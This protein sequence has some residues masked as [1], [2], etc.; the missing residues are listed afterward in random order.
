MSSLSSRQAR[1]WTG[2][3]GSWISAAHLSNL[4]V[5]YC[6]VAMPG[7]HAVEVRRVISHPMAH[8]HYS[9]TLAQLGVDRE[10][11][12]DTVDTVEM[13]RLRS[14][15]MLD[16]T[17]IT[18]PRASDLDV[19][20]HGLQ[21]ESWN[22]THFRLLSKPPSPVTLPM[23]ADT[24]GRAPLG[25]SSTDGAEERKIE[26]VS[27]KGVC[28]LMTQS[29]DFTELKVIEGTR[30]SDPA[31]TIRWQDGPIHDPAHADQAWL[32]ADRIFFP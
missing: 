15:R 26:I 19:L 9:R 7:V 14:N 12:E 18:S 28:D 23:D 25:H 30:Q 5:H 11:I 21:D 27:F 24:G 3:F 10:P 8:A 17:A 6:L 2:I 4:F 22:V 31:R 16:T 13:L 32:S 20:A 1:K 29:E